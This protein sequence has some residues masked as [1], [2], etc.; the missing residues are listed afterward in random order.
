MCPVPKEC[1]DARV[2][3]A[4]R[5]MQTVDDQWKQPGGFSWRSC[6]TG[7]PASDECDPTTD[8]TRDNA[9]AFLTVFVVQCAAIALGHVQGSTFHIN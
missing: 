7:E 2:Q 5:A 9:L 4:T 8:A 3:N 6:T 1:I